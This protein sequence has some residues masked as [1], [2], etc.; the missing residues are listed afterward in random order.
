MLPL[1]GKEGTVTVLLKHTIYTI[2]HFT[3]VCLVPWPLNRSEAGGD[4]VLLKTFLLFIGKS[5]YSHATKPVNM[6][7][8]I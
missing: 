3:V 4:L 2:G 7:I 5:W 8:H 6:I 1:P